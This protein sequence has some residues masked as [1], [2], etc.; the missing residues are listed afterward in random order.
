MRHLQFPS[1]KGGI[2][3]PGAYSLVP[4]HFRIAQRRTERCA[5]SLVPRLFRIAQRRTE[6]CKEIEGLRRG[7]HLCT[8]HK[9]ARRLTP[10]GRK[11]A[12]SGRK[13]RQ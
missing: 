5:Y 12:L 1:R 2:F 8:P 11:R 6:R 9:E 3:R 13:L 4:R 7:V 10:P